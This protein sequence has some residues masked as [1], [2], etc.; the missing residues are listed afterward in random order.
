MMVECSSNRGTLISPSVCVDLDALVIVWAC[1][2]VVLSFEVNDVDE[3]GWQNTE[4][5]MED[6][7]CA[8]S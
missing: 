6:G 2:G 5:S 8:P 7:N 4:R 3:V 1:E